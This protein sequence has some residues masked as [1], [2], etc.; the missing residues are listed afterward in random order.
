MRLFVFEHVRDNLH[1]C[2]SPFS[3]RIFCVT[4][5]VIIAQPGNFR[6]SLASA[7]QLTVKRRQLEP[8][9]PPQPYKQLKM[10]GNDDVPD[11]LEGI[12]F[13]INNIADEVIAYRLALQ[14]ALI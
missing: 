1:Y 10:A 5:G 9:T 6:S 8:R 11:S 12:N 3:M 13:K 7:D 4:L 2:A 14:F